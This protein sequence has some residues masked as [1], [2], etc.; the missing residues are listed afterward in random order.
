MPV[1]EAFAKSILLI[2][3]PCTNDF[4]EPQNITVMVSSLLKPSSLPIFWVMNSNVKNKNNIPEASK[5]M[6]M[7]ENP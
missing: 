1:I 5:S 2:T 6:S 7:I 3:V 4:F